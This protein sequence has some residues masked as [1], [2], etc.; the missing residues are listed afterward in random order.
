[1]KWLVVFLTLCSCATISGTWTGR[2]ESPNSVGV[3]FTIEERDGQLTGR[4]FWEDPV[5][6]QLEPE[7][8]LSGKREKH[9]ASWVTEGSVTVS[10]TVD[11]DHFV[12]TLTFPAEG[13]ARART[14]PVKLS[15]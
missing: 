5:S 13:N 3:R 8:T 1:M 2:L 9:D 10:G 11:G 4:T 6:H 14:A 7:G 15:R 12:G